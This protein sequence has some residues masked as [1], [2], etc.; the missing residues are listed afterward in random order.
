MTRLVLSP[1]VVTTTASAS[2]IPA[3]R[4]SFRSMPWPTTKPPVQL[5]PS[6][7]RASSF[8]SRTVTSQPEPC[9][10]SA[11]AEPTRPH[12]TTSAFTFSAYSSGALC[13]RELL[14]EHRL[15][16]RDDQHLARRPPEDV[17]DRRREEPRLPAPPRRGAEDDQVRVDLRGVRDDRLAD[18]ARTDRRPLHRHVEVGAE[19]LR[20]RERRLG[21]LLLLEQR[22]VER[23]V[24]R[25]ANDVQRTH[26][27]VVLGRELDG[28][29]HH[30]LADHPEL[31]R[32]DDPLE[33][34]S[35]HDRSLV[36]RLDALEQPFTAREAA[37]DE[38]GEPR[39]QPERTCVARG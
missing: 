18:R 6:R 11:T 9:S 27:R 20:L 39:Q 17:V 3:S 5:S 23:L 10:C 14:V 4:S 36:R 21:A 2:S 38:D 29:G 8:S 35:G 1:S 19:Q 16:E 33:L 31:H 37:A 12:P 22:R 25:D 32:H 26:L 28:G 30:L 13:R 34:R 24:E 15:R 7:P